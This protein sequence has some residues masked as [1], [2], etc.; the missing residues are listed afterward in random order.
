MKHHLELY[1][2][3]GWRRQSDEDEEGKTRT[4]KKGYKESKR[5]TGQ[6]DSA[7]V[8]VSLPLSLLRQILGTVAELKRGVKMLVSQE[9]KENCEITRVL[10][11]ST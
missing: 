5:H 9:E 4:K 8:E 6:I 7:G 2:P 11:D 1:V 3:S 10:H